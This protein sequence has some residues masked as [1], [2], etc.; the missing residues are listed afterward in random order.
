V[1]AYDGTHFA[2]WQSQQGGGAIQDVKIL[3]QLDRVGEIAESMGVA[4]AIIAMPGA[5]HPARKRALD[6]C[7][8]AGLRVMTVPAYAD[9]VSGKV[10]ISQ[11][12]EVELDD[13]LGRDPVRLDDAQLSG[14][15]K[16]KRVLVTGAGGFAAGCCATAEDNC[17][18][19]AGPSS[20][21]A[22][23]VVRHMTRES[24]W[25]L[26]MRVTSPERCSRGRRLE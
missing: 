9:I 22:S 3:G 6:L 25:P 24:E 15:L 19:T 11:L 7:Q 2:G 21:P 17:A 12:R 4:Q 5:T 16:G 14:F 18:V 10:S 13:L 8:A 23:S 1:C 26:R 20:V